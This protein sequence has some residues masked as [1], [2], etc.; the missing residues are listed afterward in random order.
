[1]L[2]QVT[3]TEVAAEPS[4]ASTGREGLTESRHTHTLE[5]AAS[6]TVAAEMISQTCIVK[7]DGER[8]RPD[9]S[10]LHKAHLGGDAEG[11]C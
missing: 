4:T 1:M 10:A 9:L 7:S 3:L 5:H 11:G 6:V 2:L 8:L